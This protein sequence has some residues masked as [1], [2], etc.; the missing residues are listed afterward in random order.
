MY[1]SP[2]EESCPMF[3]LSCMMKSNKKAMIVSQKF[4]CE[5]LIAPVG[6][7]NASLIIILCEPLILFTLHNHMSIIKNIFFIIDLFLKKKKGVIGQNVLMVN[8]KNKQEMNRI[9]EVHATQ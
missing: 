8:P 5:I 1:L 7:M 2:A 3:R 4:L 6:N 9:Y